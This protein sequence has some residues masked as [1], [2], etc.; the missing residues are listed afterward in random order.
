MSKKDKDLN[1]NEASLLNRFVEYKA[2]W[3]DGGTYIAKVVEV[4]KTKRWTL[5][6]GT[7][8]ETVKSTR[9]VKVVHNGGELAK[10]YK[11]AKKELLVP[12]EWLRTVYLK[13]SAHGPRRGIPFNEW[14]LR[15]P[16]EASK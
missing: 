7:K 10:R 12:L 2:P 6:V 13:K 9:A 11:L 15:N 16:K 5:G 1:L 4:G 8:E 14:V 3:P